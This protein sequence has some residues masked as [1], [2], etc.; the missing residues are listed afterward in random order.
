MLGLQHA[1]AERRLRR[2]ARAAQKLLAIPAGDNVVR[3]LPPL[4]VDEDEI[5]EAVAPAR[6]AP[7]RRSR[8]PMRALAERGA[9]E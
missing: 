4:I 8:A 9:A 3:L 7:A 6:R 5:G 2:R 1:R